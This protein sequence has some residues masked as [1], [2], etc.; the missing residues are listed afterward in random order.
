MGEE[1][2]ALEE[3]RWYRNL[4]SCDCVRWRVSKPLRGTMGLYLTEAVIAYML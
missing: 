3:V 4:L 2:A 1:Q